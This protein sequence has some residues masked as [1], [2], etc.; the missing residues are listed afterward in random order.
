MLS[1]FLLM[2]SRINVDY[3]FI[4]WG[5]CMVSLS[6]SCFL[7]TVFSN[8]KW[9]VEAELINGQKGDVHNLHE[10]KIGRRFKK[11]IL[12]RGILSSVQLLIKKIVYFFSVSIEKMRQLAKT[13]NHYPV[14]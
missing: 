14:N 8:E 9:W 13:T 4:T 3:N 7:R 12:I 6:K 5:I 10:V 2:M 11:Q 1:V